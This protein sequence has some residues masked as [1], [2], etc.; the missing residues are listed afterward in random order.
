MGRPCLDDEDYMGRGAPSSDG[1]PFWG[2]PLPVKD[3]IWGAPSLGND[4]YMGHGA[5]LFQYKTRY[6]AS[7]SQD[8]YIGH[9]AP[10]F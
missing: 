8:E 4:E 10:L 1:A 3:E 2:A 9:G 5:P 7:P 6:G